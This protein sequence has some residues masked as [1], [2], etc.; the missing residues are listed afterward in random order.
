M[1]ASIFFL[2]HAQP[3]RLNYFPDR[4]CAEGSGVLLA[5][6]FV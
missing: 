2:R 3:L 5:N 4:I 6:G 1:K